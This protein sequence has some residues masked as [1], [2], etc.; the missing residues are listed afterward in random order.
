MSF[1]RPKGANTAPTD[2]FGISDGAARKRRSYK[3][4]GTKSPRISNSSRTD[5]N[6][7]VEATLEGREPSNSSNPG[8]PTAHNPSSGENGEGNAITAGKKI[9]KGILKRSAAVPLPLGSPTKH[10]PEEYYHA[11]K[12]LKKAMLEA[13]RLVLP[14]CIQQPWLIHIK[15]RARNSEQ[16]SSESFANASR[17][18]LRPLD[19]RR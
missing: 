15:Q 14:A 3:S 2:K 1:I 12:K 5:L 13:Y 6:K 10:D 4:N 17:L 8:S 16:L 7:T 19:G 9:K 18:K 11:K